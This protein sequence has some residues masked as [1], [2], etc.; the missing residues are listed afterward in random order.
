[1]K[2]GR[3]PRGKGA[4]RA[5]VRGRTYV[6][7]AGAAEILGRGAWFVWRMV[8]RGVDADG[9]GLIIGETVAVGVGVAVGDAAAFHST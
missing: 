9:V 6:T 2:G 7:T 3:W 8:K 1:M 5:V 4:T